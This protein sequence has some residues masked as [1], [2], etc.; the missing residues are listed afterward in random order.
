MFDENELFLLICG[1][2][3]TFDIGDMKNNATYS[4]FTYDHPTIRYFWKVVEEMDT[5]QRRNLLKFVTSSS[6]PPLLGFKDMNPPVCIKR[7]EGER[8]RLPT[9]STC[10]NLLKLPAYPT[11]NEMREKLLL[12]IEHGNS[13]FELT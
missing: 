9:S 6:R 5:S 1:S 11:L 2:E 7:S 3:Q 10:L 12:A 13:T 8:D 4:G